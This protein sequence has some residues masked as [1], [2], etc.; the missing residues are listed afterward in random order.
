MDASGS[1]AVDAGSLG[2]L[3]ILSVAVAMLTSMKKLKMPQV[4]AMRV[5]IKRPSM[6]ISRFVLMSPLMNSKIT[7][8]QIM[9]AARVRK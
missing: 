4:M 2:G 7:S 9:A 6:P 8:I 5:K 1:L 3:G